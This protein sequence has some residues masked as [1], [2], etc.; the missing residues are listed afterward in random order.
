MSG[1]TVE[2]AFKKW[3]IY[4][5]LFFG[6]AVSGVIL[7]RSFTAV[8]FKAVSPGTGTHHWIDH[9]HNGVIDFKQQQ[10]FQAQKNGNFKQQNAWEIL[11][12]IHW[13]GTTFFWLFLAILG[14][15]G[16]DLAYMWRIRILSKNDLSWK[17]SF[18]V[19]MLWE[20]ASALAPGVLS[21]ATVAM[22]ILNR[23]RISMGRATAMVIITAFFDNLFYVVMIP[24]VFLFLSTDQ[25]FPKNVPGSTTVSSIFWTGYTVFFALCMVLYLSI[26]RFPN[27]IKNLLSAITRLSFLKKWQHKA[28]KTGE[29][30]ALTAQW[31][32]GEP[33]SF[34]MKTFLA[35]VA[36]W[37]SRYLVINFVLQAFVHLGLLQHIQLFAKQF[38]LWM[39]LRV[40]PTPG[41]SGVAEWAFGELLVNFAGSAVLLGTMAVI[42]RLISYFPYLLIGSILFPRWLRSAQ[43]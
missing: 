29:D 16:R 43:E 28:I 8:E 35:T 19:I 26:F 38:V 30:I 24:L 10:E 25:L 22:F 36:S 3:K 41:G 7:Y 1:G 17:R 13:T 11:R 4:L 27:L 2:S 33:F 12:H 6:L 40:S 18:Y 9:N 15:V 42:W 5:A 23:E 32:K 37:T 34:W 39:F 31:M 20:F 14:M 21:G